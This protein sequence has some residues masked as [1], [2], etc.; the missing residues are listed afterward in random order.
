MTSAPIAPPATE[1]TPVSSS[2]PLTGDALLNRFQALKTAGVVHSDIA[3]ECGYY[4]SVTQGE[5][6]GTVRASTS[7]LNAALLEAQGLIAARKRGSQRSS[8]NRAVVNKAGRA[9]ISA[10]MLEALGVEPG[11]YLTAE[12]VEGGLLLKVAG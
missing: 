5:A 9:T 2:A 4:T 7:K 11:Q 12:A 6:A 10:G 1:E 8:C 3:V